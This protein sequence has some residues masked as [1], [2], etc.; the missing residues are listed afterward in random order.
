MDATSRLG[1]L[2]E[3]CAGAR[4]TIPMMIGAAPFGVIFGTLCSA[5]PLSAW[6]GQLMLRDT[7]AWR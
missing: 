4:D 2:S 7:P 1:N 3:F 6:Y 5:G